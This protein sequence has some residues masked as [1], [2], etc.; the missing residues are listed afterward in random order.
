MSNMMICEECGYLC[1]RDDIG[2]VSEWRGECHGV[3][4]Y[5]DVIDTCPHCGGTF[6]ATVECKICGSYHKDE[7]GWIGYCDECLEKEATF[8]MATEIGKDN[9]ES[10]KVNGLITH[11]FT[12]DEIEAILLDYAKNHQERDENAKT[13]CLGDMFCLANYLDDKCK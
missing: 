6:V 13:Y 10:V 3:E 7:W 9:K 2:T 8:E 4:C 5:E 11:M 12:A 1:D